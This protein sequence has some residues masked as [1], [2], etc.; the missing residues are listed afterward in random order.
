MKGCTSKN[1]TSTPMN[2]PIAAPVSSIT[3]ATT[4]D[5]RPS[6]MRLAPSIPVKAITAPTDRSIPPVRMTKV[7]PTARISR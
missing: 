1:C 2:R 3:G 5:G 6:R 7:I 4:A